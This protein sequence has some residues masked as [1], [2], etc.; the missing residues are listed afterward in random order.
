MPTYEYVCDKCGKEFTVVEG[1]QAHRGT[2]PACPT[3]KSKSTRQVMSA[4]YANTIK[5][6]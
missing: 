4:F 5:K 1:M 3:C 2:P 6:S